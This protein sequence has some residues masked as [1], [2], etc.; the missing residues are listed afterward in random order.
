MRRAFIVL[1]AV[2]PALV[3]SCQS[4]LP[5]SLYPPDPLL[6][7]KKPLAE[8]RSV[9]AKVAPTVVAVAE[10]LPPPVPTSAVF[11]AKLQVLEPETTTLH[12][13]LPVS[14][15]PE[16]DYG[17]APDF[18][19]LIGTLEK[20]CEGHVELRYRRPGLDGPD[21]KVRLEDDPRLAALGDGE[22]V[23]VEGAL[24]PTLVPPPSGSLPRYKATAI[25]RICP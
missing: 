6:V 20:T 2:T 21:G 15:V 9:I 13:P 22:T 17:A 1:A 7:L 3:A 8:A 18:H 23:K 25:T 16:P 12:A 10:P 19:W 11:S 24:V 4:P 5:S 14:F